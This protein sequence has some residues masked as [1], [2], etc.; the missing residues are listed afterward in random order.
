MPAWL[1]INAYRGI[2]WDPVS[3]LR[4]QYIRERER[5]RERERERVREREREQFRKPEDFGSFTYSPGRR[6]SKQ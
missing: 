1:A 6:I 2:S 5:K 3:I 4:V